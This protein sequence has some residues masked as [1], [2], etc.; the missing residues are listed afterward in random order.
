MFNVEP[1]QGGGSRS[2]KAASNAYHPLFMTGKPL[3]MTN[4]AMDH[5]KPWPI[6][7]DD[8]PS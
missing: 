6:E 7:I 2:Q 1:S 3:V 5:W 4:V 8:F